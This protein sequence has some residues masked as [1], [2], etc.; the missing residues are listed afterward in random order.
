MGSD[1]PALP[2]EGCA[3]LAVLGEFCCVFFGEF[4]ILRVPDFNEEYFA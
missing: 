1:L 3:E 2:A 4:P